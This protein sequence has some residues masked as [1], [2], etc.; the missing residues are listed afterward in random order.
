MMIQ[1]P[2]LQ[3][4]FDPPRWLEVG[5]EIFF[6]AGVL[7]AGWWGSRRAHKRTPGLSADLKG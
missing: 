7:V 5:T 4:R 6:T 1:D 2:W 3:Q